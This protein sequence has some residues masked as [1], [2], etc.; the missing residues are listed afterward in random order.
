[1]HGEFEIRGPIVMFR[2]ETPEWGLLP[3]KQFRDGDRPLAGR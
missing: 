2:D 3:E 1:M